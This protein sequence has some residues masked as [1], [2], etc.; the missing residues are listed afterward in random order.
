MISPELL[1][2]YPFFAGVDDAQLKALANIASLETFNSGTTLFHE[3][4]RAESLYF[5]MEGSVVL[6]YMGIGTA[7][8]KFPEGVPVG[9]I[10]PGEPFSIS[11]LIEPHVLTSTARVSKPSRVLRFNAQTLQ[12]LLAKDQRLAYTLTHQAAT[13]VVDRLL[14]TRIQL[15]AAWAQPV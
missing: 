1:A 12:E 3:G 5:L 2:R 15:A 7:L 13:A 10:N 8:E 4:D 14:T 9:E 6:Y 11:A